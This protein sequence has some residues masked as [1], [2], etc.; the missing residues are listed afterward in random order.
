MNGESKAKQLS[1]L[2]ACFQLNHLTSKIGEITL[3]NNL[4]VC[5]KSLASVA[6]FTTP[7]FLRNLQMGLI[8]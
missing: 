2:K 7:H 1:T 4:K 6:V 5:K 8:S 3:I